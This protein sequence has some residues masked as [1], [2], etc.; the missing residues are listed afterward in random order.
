M[1]SSKNVKTKLEHFKD[2]EEIK[3]CI[4]LL[5][6]SFVCDH[7]TKVKLSV[8]KIVTHVNIKLDATECVSKNF[9]FQI[10]YNAKK[11]INNLQH[12]NQEML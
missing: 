4:F 1:P 10:F 9:N 5:D 8:S 7:G 6:S 11:S 12:N 2:G 3:I